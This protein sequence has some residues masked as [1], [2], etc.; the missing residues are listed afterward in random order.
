[1]KELIEYIAKSIVDK[2]EEVVVV[3]E[4]VAD[5]VVLKLQVA[6]EDT[7]KVIGKE[8]RIAKAMRTLLRV[9]AIRKGTRA[10]LEIVSDSEPPRS[11]YRS[12][13]DSE[14]GSSYGPSSDSEP[15]SSQ[16]SDKY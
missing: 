2:P 5:G 3:E 14:P 10:T 8:G 12:S 1:M 9:A 15:G 7:G 6:P 16:A 13:S 4:A 11:S